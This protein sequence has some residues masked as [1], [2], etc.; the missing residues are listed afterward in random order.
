MNEQKKSLA[1]YV[2]KGSYIAFKCLFTKYN[3]PWDINFLFRLYNV[4]T[5]Q[6]TVFYGFFALKMLCYTSFIIFWN[7]LQMVS[8]WLIHVGVKYIKTFKGLYCRE[9]FLGHNVLLCTITKCGVVG[10]LCIGFWN[11]CA[12]SMFQSM[13]TSEPWTFIDLYSP[14]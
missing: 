2:F 10:K 6:P 5:L 8:I 1:G 3:F 13:R 12:T 9:L 4:Y 11:Y 7:T 14:E